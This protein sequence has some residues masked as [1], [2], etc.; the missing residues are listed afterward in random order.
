MRVPIPPLTQ[1]RRKDL[2]KM[3]KKLAEEAKGALRTHRR[4]ANEM[5]KELTDSGDVSEDDERQG[6]KK[7]QDASDKYTAS[8]DDILGKKETEILEG[9]WNARRLHSRRIDPSCC[10]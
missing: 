4:E 3:I 7:V 6:L 9:R 5:L 2:V 10:Q 8:V 1:E